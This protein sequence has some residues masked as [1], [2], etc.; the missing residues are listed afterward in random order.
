MMLDAL[1]LLSRNLNSG[2]TLSW[3]HTVLV[4]VT[5]QNILTMTNYSV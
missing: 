2:D 1:E 5:S 4:N 3:G